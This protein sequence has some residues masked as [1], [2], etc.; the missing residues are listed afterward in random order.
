MK[1]GQW[2]GRAGIE[3]KG[4]RLVLPRVLD[5][6]PP[7]CSWVFLPA[8]QGHGVSPQRAP[9]GGQVAVQSSQGWAVPGERAVLRPCS[10][11]GALVHR[12]GPGRKE[13]DGGEKKN[14]TKRDTGWCGRDGASPQALGSGEGPVPLFSLQPQALT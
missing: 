6:L 10:P 8:S 5:M 2:R 1:Q 9:G 4:D 7:C 11:V 13:G 12:K 14:Q 3:A